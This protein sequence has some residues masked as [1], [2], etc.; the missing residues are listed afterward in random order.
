MF[1]IYGYEHRQRYLTGYSRGA[2]ACAQPPCC[3]ARA[4]YDS[5]MPDVSLLHVL[6]AGVAHLIIGFVWYHPRVFGGIWMRL[7]NMSPE[8]VEKG[9]RRMPISAALA[10]LAGLVVAYVMSFML[11]VLV[12]P[13]WIGAIELGFWCWLGF[14]APPMLGVVLWEQKPFSLYLLNALY[15]LVSFVVMAIVLVL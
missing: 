4:R 10:F 11:P 6:A 3:R 13:D 9:K 15:W 1:E 2:R 8:Q 12:Y 5:D 7:L 14:V